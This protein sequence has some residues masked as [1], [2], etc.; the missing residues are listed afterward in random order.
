MNNLNALRPVT[1]RAIPLFY[2][3]PA[4]CELPIPFTGSGAS[5][6]ANLDIEPIARKSGPATLEAIV[7]GNEVSLNWSSLPYAFAWVVYRAT[8]PAGPFTLLTANLLVTS[9][10][11]AGLAAGTYYYKTTAI[12][13]DFGETF[14]SPLVEVTV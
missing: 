9:Y 1:R 2:M 4:I 3:S 14:P 6:A 5:V 13:P 8:N 10:V 12:E 7:V 11:D